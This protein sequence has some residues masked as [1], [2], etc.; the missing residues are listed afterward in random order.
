MVGS[1]MYAVGVE[2]IC[3][4][5]CACPAE[6]IDYTCIKRARLDKIYDE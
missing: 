1:G 3:E 5:L 2:L 4:F 6:A